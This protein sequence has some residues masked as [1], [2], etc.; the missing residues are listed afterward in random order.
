LTK[1]DLMRLTK[2]I[3][4]NGFASRRKKKKIRFRIKCVL[5]LIPIASFRAHLLKVSIIKCGCL[6]LKVATHFALAM[7]F[8]KNTLRSFIDLQVVILPNSYL[9]PL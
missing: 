8:W 2:W 9:I 7:R 3:C 1:S 6:F 4:I 5:F